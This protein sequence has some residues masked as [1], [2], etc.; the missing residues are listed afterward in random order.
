MYQRLLLLLLVIAVAQVAASVK[1]HRSAR[2]FFIKPTPSSKCDGQHCYTMS[3][4]ARYIT[5]IYQLSSNTTIYFLPGTHVINETMVFLVKHTDTITLTDT[6]MSP[7][8]AVTVH[9]VEKAGFG[10]MNV[11]NIYVTGIDFVACGLKLP[12]LLPDDVYKSSF[13]P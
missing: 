2:T 3:E 8:N 11:S 7:D 1:P 4:F 13:I 10:F 5:T 12:V 6:L 9:C